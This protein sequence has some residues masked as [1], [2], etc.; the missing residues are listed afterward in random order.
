MKP[1]SDYMYFANVPSYLC[2]CAPLSRCHVVS[3]PGQLSLAVPPWVGAMTI[4]REGNSIDLPSHWPCVTVSHTLMAYP[5]MRA[6]RPMLQRWASRLCSAWAVLHFSSPS[7]L[8]WLLYDGD[9]IV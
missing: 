5:P 1:S 4:S 3:H 8:R 2:W 7:Y 6:Q 9:T